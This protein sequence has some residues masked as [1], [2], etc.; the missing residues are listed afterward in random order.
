MPQPGVS[1]I[2]GTA[3]INASVVRP[4]S[5]EASGRPRTEHAR[6]TLVNSAARIPTTFRYA[7]YT[8]IAS[9]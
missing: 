1:H 7:G 2:K 9:P 5:T 3:T 4:N 8:K 6:K